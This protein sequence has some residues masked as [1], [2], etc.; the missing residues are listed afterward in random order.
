MTITANLINVSNEEIQKNY[1]E[2][3]QNY[4]GIKSVGKKLVDEAENSYEYHEAF[5]D[6]PEQFSFRL[7]GIKLVAIKPEKNAE[8]YRED[9]IL[10]NMLSFTDFM[11]N[12][13]EFDMQVRGNF[14]VQ[15]MKNNGFAIYGKKD[16][17]LKDSRY[18]EWLGG[19]YFDT[20]DRN[21]FLEKLEDFETMFM[22]ALGGKVD[23]EKV[24]NLI[25][26]RG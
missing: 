19:L 23:E 12:A 15:K 18:S 2:L 8:A 17:E 11:R 7:F 16:P 3:L 21:E 10:D 5:L 26:R 13:K 14:L 20:D 22:P 9:L 4:P 6:E 25:K 1:R 24:N